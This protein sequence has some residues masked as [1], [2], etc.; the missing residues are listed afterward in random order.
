MNKFSNEILTMMEEDR[1]FRI[2]FKQEQFATYFIEKMT[3]KME[4]MG[5]S[6]ADLAR[7]L[8]K[9]AAYISKLLNKEQNLTIKTMIDL[10]D[11]IEM[12][13]SIYLKPRATSIRAITIA[14]SKS[15]PSHISWSERERN[16][17]CYG[18]V[19]EGAVLPFIRKARMSPAS[20]RNGWVSTIAEVCQDA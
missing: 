6:G 17:P 18:K 20:I 5:M 15:N 19:A 14:V 11:A 8:D 1:E 7:T 10:A 4:L 12:D 2:S 16:S 9:S 3:E 13:I